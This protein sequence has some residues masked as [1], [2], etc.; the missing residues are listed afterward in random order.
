MASAQDFYSQFHLRPLPLYARVKVLNQV[1]TPQILYRLECIPPIRSHLDHLGILTRKFLLALSDAPSFLVQKTLFSHKKVGLGAFHLPTLVPQRVLDIAHRSIALLLPSPNVVGCN[2]WLVQCV[3]AACAALCLPTSPA[4]NQV[5][6]PPSDLTSHFLPELDIP[7][8]ESPLPLSLPE[9]TAYADGSFFPSISQCAS[10]VLLP[11]NRSAT[12]KPRGRPSCY[13]AEVYALAL[14]VA[15]VTEGTSIYTDS[16]AALHAI[17]GN[18]IR[19]TLA[20]PI[21]FIRRAVFRKSL[22]LCHVRGHIGIQGNEAADRIAKHACKTLPAPPPQEPSKPWDVCV[23]GELQHPPHKTWVRDLTPR[24]SHED[25]H[26]WSWKVLGRPGWLTWLFGAKA[27][28]GFAHPSTF[29]RNQA[30]ASMCTHC[31]TFHNA[32]IH[33]T[34]GQCPNINNPCVAAWLCAWG[35]HQHMAATW[36]GAASSR[37]RYLLGKLVLP[38]SLVVYLKAHLGPRHARSAVNLFHRNI[39]SQLTATLPSWTPAEKQ[40]FKRRLNPYAPEGWEDGPAPLPPPAPRRVRQRLP[41]RASPQT[42]PAPH[43]HHASPSSRAFDPQ[44]S[45]RTFFQPLRPPTPDQCP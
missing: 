14:A 15:L 41:H 38:N 32:S 20:G 44:P 7:Y 19:V 9:G 22:T 16:A 21:A 3:S 1:I 2:G 34:I 13:R 29:W 27:A 17:H 42:P 45:I 11:N 33:G 30:S 43:S 25:I 35:P 24:H 39:L 6:P 36:R 40:T 31:S 26:P 28:K 18:S 4:P 23:A 8:F 10:A 5:A 37:D 12:L